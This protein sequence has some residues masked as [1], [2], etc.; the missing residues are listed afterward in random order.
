MAY[1]EFYCNYSTGSNMNGGS[2]E[3]TSPS[4]SATN[5][6]WNSGTGVF[7][8][9][10]GDPSAS[11]TV[12]EYA[13][14]FTDGSTTPTFIGRV[15][16]VDSTT[17]T[18][19]TTL[20]SGTAPT[21]A[22]SGISINVGGVWKG[23]NGSSGFPFNFMQATQRNDNST[24][25]RVNFK[26]N[27]TYDITATMTCIT[28]AG[29]IVF[30]GY[31]TTPG[32]G[33]EAKI[34]GGASGTRYQLLTT[35]NYTGKI[36]KN[37]WF[38][39]NGATSTAQGLV[40]GT[41]A[42]MFRCRFSHSSAWACLNAVNIECEAHDNTTYGFSNGNC[43]RCISHHNGTNGWEVTSPSFG[44][45][46]SC[47][48]HHNGSAGFNISFTGFMGL[49]NCDSYANGGAGLAISKS[50]G[51]TPQNVY[52]ENC[53][54][55]DNGTYG[56]SQSGAGTQVGFILE[57]VGFGAGTM[58]NTS[59][60]FQITGD[61]TVMY[62]TSFS[63][64]NDVT[65]WTDPDTG[66]FKINLAAAMNAGHGD[67]LQLNG[68]YTGTV[69]YPDIGA[70]Q[71]DDTGGGGG[72]GTDQATVVP[73]SGGDIQEDNGNKVFAFATYFNG[74]PTALTGG[75]IQ[76]YLNGGSAETSGV[77]LGTIATGVYKVTVDST[78]AEFNG[79][80]D[81]V[82]TLSA[83]TVGG[84]DVTNAKVGEF[85]I[86]RYATEEEVQD[87]IATAVIGSALTEPTAV[88][89]A[90]ATLSDKI[91]WIYAYF[92]N[93]VTVTGSARTLYA[94]DETTVLGAEVLDD[95]DTTFDKNE[96]T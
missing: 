85:S 72:G 30:E 89:A 95:D 2:E 74:V 78:N 84:I 12:G 57:K 44:R 96:A 70:A 43:F 91:G 24:C 31:T 88:P 63:Y 34:D 14:V 58:A 80:G 64:A 67:F 90:N 13:H 77:T 49:K 75:A 25:A 17:V 15:T 65:P 47:I 33:G 79:G 92:R 82:V 45:H 94:D 59:G 40:N 21:T 60:D 50:G 46:E 39:R 93:R 23:P 42:V 62:D 55:V 9:T 38:T 20:K 5:G 51:S 3:A 86:N 87:G 27:A 26:N 11:V 61:G 8:P 32:D 6:G 48:A 22:G 36:W 56:I 52:L 76:F 4:Y 83:G 10:S 66:D 29:Q 1:T 81:I 19:S 35:T 16:A 69:G 37:F 53:N 73:F 41:G 18:V 7:T 71:H 54:F 28:D 68:T